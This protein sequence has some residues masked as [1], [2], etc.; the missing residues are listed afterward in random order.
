MARVHLRCRLARVTS[1]IAPGP[2]LFVA[3]VAV[4][5]LLIKDDRVL[6][7]R[8]YQTGYEDGNYS[9]VA[10]HIDG[11]EEL[12]D[13]MIREAKE[14]AGIVIH[15]SNLEVVGVLHLKSDRE[16]L[17]FFLVASTWFGEITNEEP[18]KCDDLRWFSLYDLPRNTIPYIRRAIENYRNGIWFDSVGW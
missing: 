5:L 2:A 17:A 11:G 9:V 13:A 10:G 14:E 15:R 16:Y 4:H 8:R 1:D 12:K 3:P 18:D 7:L 6:L